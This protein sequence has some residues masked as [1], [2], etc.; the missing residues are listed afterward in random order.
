MESSFHI[1]FCCRIRHDY[2]LSGSSEDFVLEPTADCRQVLRDH[3]MIYKALPDGGMVV[4]EKS[5]GIIHRP[6]TQPVRF[7]LKMQLRQPRFAYFTDLGTAP[8]AQIGRRLFYFSNLSTEGIINPPGVMPGD[9][10]PLSTA[11]WVGDEDIYRIIP[12]LYHLPVN[13]QQYSQ[14][15]IFRTVAG[16]GEISVFSQ[17]IT[18]DASSA[19][20]DLRP[21][22]P[23]SYRLQWTGDGDPSEKLY[24]DEEL[25]YEHPFGLIEIFADA[26]T[27]YDDQLFI[28]Y[29]L[30][31]HRLETIWYYH[32]IDAGAQQAMD[33][34]QID[35]PQDTAVAPYPTEATFI[36]TDLDDV[37]PDRTRTIATA[38]PPDRVRLFRSSAPLP[39][40]Q[41]PLPDLALSRLAGTEVLYPQLPNPNPSGSGADIIVN[42]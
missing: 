40:Y 25:I 1:L 18:S 36:P 26:D 6:L 27:V 15:E 10:L 29:Q 9:T 19:L 7:R 11:I 13:P 24:V 12:P 38:F 30:P 37:L 17:S 23:G 5:A 3:G 4:Y 39:I 34:L 2:Y 35:Y 14:M 8:A 32:I 41:Q 16:Q 20:L 42:I 21:Y 33:T 31:F 22:P 28:T